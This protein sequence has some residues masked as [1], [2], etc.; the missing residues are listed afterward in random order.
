MLR[1][2]FRTGRLE[3]FPTHPGERDT[4]LALAG[5]KL[6][7]RRPYAEREVNRALMEWLASVRAAPDHVTV[8]RRMVDCGFL[9]RTPSGSRYYLNYGRVVE[10]LGDPPMTVDAGAIVDEIVRERAERKRAYAA[11]A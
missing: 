1:R 10:A 9:K 3:W 7:R 8:R 6:E 5:C 4:L 2:L 11:G